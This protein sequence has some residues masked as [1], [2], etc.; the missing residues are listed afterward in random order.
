M[1]PVSNPNEDDP[2]PVIF[3]R[4]V[5]GAVRRKMRNKEE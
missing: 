5:K 4:L 1:H 2:S 3:K